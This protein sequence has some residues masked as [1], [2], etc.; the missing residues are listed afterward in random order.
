[1][2]R[3]IAHIKLDGTRILAMLSDSVLVGLSYRSL[4]LPRGA[5]SCINT[6][7]STRRRLTPC[8]INCVLGTLVNTYGNWDTFTNYSHN[9]DNEWALQYE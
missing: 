4:P 9:S 3:N 6:P 5:I 2:Y 1:M 7:A 8:Y